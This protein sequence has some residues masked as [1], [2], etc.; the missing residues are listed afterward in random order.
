MYRAYMSRI[1]KKW[2][3]APRDQQMTTIYYIN[4]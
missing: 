3:N 4:N 2:N 1:A